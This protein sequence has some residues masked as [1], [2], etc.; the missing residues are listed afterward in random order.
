MK[1]PLKIITKDTR[2]NTRQPSTLPGSLEKQVML[3]FYVTYFYGFVIK[4]LNW[5]CFFAALNPL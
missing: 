5:I 3:A 4:Y 2:L 1:H